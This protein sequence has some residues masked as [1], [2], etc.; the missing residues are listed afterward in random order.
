[1]PAAADDQV[2]V[3]SDTQRLGG[4]DDVA[5]HRD[6]GFRRGRIARGM[7]VRQSICCKN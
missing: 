4:I 6:V 5:G 7:V 1:M 3:H 2:V